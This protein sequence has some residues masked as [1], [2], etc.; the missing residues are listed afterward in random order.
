MLKTYQSG[1]LSVYQSDFQVYFVSYVHVPNANY[2]RWVYE[3][4]SL[5]HH[6]YIR[7]KLK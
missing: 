4:E 7:D 5:F 1:S 3:E 6:R 2:C